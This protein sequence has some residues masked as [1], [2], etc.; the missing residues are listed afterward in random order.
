MLKREVCKQSIKF[1]VSKIKVIEEMIK[2]EIAQEIYI[3]EKQLWER[4]ESQRKN[5]REHNQVA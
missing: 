2:T 3:E 4:K 1:E 5:I